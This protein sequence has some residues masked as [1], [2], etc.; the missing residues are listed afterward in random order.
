MIDYVMLCCP[1]RTI[2]REYMANS[3]LVSFFNIYCVRKALPPSNLKSKFTQ[4]KKN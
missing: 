3:T 1:S 4:K 2:Y